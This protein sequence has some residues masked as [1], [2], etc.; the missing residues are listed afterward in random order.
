MPF[1]DYPVA[2]DFLLTLAGLVLRVISL[3]FGFIAA[4]G[5]IGILVLVLIPVGLFMRDIHAGPKAFKNHK[6]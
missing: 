1:F 3:V 4:I 5:P 6:A 2:P